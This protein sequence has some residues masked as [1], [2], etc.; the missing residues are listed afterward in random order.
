MFYI[1]YHIIKI[2]L[3]KGRYYLLQFTVKIDCFIETQNYDV[4]SLAFITKS[5]KVTDDG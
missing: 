2:P 4:L 1:K 3:C 5:L